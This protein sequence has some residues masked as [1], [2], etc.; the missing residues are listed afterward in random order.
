MKNF[1]R[2]AADH[3]DARLPRLGSAE[4]F[5][6]IKECLN[7]LIGQWARASYHCSAYMPLDL[8]PD[9]SIRTD[10]PAPGKTVL[11]DIDFS[12]HFDKFAAHFTALYGE[13]FLSGD[14]LLQHLD[15]S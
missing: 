2:G 11:L 8:Q 15:I 10:L 12:E 6:M 13:H 4:H 9:R 3:E 5:G 1:L 14:G 7:E